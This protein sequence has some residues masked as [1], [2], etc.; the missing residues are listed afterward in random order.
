MARPYDIRKRIL[1]T[2][3][4]RLSRSTLDRPATGRGA[5]S[6]LRHNLFTGTKHN[7]EHLHSYPRFEFTRHDVTLTT[8]TSCSFATR[9][10][11]S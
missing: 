1:V 7:I 6:A 4:S 2:G 9:H 8:K 5:R 11:R 3:G 10:S